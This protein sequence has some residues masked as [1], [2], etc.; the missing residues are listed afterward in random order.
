MITLPVYLVHPRPR[1]RQPH[2]R[3]LPPVHPQRAVKRKQE[4]CLRP[5]RMSPVAPP[6]AVLS[7]PW[8]CSFSPSS[9]FPWLLPMAWAH[10]ERAFMPFHRMGWLWYVLIGGR[11]GYGRVDA[12]TYNA[13]RPAPASDLQLSRYFLLL[14]SSLPFLFTLFATPVCH[15]E[16]SAWN[17]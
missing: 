4:A 17:L 7:F 6:A 14:I 9:V 13:V 10:A 5:P 11:T 1:H 15:S 2:L 16:T 8:H 3:N 12:G